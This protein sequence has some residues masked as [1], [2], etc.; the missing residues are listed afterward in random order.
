MLNQLIAKQA[1]VLGGDFRSN[2]EGETQA[3]LI[4]IGLDTQV[5]VVL[6]ALDISQRRPILIEPL[7]GLLTPHHLAHVPQQAERIMQAESQRTQRDDQNPFFQLM[8]EARRDRCRA[9]ALIYAIETSG[10]FQGY[11]FFASSSSRISGYA[12]HTCIG[13]PE[14]DL[15]ALP[16]LDE[17][18]VERPYGEYRSLQHAVIQQCLHNADQASRGEGDSDSFF[19]L[20]E[21]ENVIRGAAERLMRE[22]A[23]RAT[24]TAYDLTGVV[25]AFSALNYER[26][27]AGGRLAIANLNRADIQLS[28]K[29][30]HPIGLQ[31]SKTMRKLLELT[32]DSSCV[33][34]DGRR[35]HGLGSYDSSPEIMEISVRGNA[36]WEMSVDGAGLMRVSHGKISLPRPP[37]DFVELEDIANRTLGTIARSRIR[38]IVQAARDTGRGTTLVISS[39]P[40]NEAQRLSGEAMLIEPQFL[41]SSIVAKLGRVDGAVLLGRDGYCHA[42]GVI[43]DGQA[44]GRGDRS[45]GSR[46][47]SAVR[48][49]KT[50][51]RM[52]NQTVLVVVSVDG[53]V[54][55][56]PALK[57]KV[58]RDVI[59]EAVS[60]F[61]AVCDA[62]RIDW[63][64]YRRAR[65][66]VEKLEFYLSEEQ[67]ERLNACSARLADRERSNRTVA[68]MSRR[69][70]R[71][72][73][74]MDDSYFL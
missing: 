9:R 17:A 4:K 8:E 57:P 50:Q 40:E 69:P 45:R 73:I 5:R 38:D 66:A 12:V 60:S 48:Y 22:V 65:A 1:T 18:V 39:D 52:G 36:R 70:F 41:A 28:V 21:P 43:L 37:I 29:F 31:D 61:C 3:A 46:F 44:D 16:T 32:D 64:M 34:T 14:P 72:D 56:V 33:L 2:V 7:G 54:D 23:A 49:Q 24:G 10:Q 63:L 15:D 74:E 26:S 20:G 59:E 6:V 30:Q 68:A 55:I 42:F 35:A 62:E 27:Q 11:R 47:N 58:H 19:L 13:I 67:C 53:S 71:P 51:Q 25:N